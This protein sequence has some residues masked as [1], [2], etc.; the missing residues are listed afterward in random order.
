MRTASENEARPSLRLPLPKHLPL[1]FLGLLGLTIL[2]AFILPLDAMNV[3]SYSSAPALKSGV[4][5]YRVHPG[6]N[7]YRIGL[8]FG[9]SQRYY[10][11]TIH[12]CSRT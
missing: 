10:I 5:T 1:F 2:S 3:L 6:D 12:A 8:R 11:S 9:V 7:L 4:C